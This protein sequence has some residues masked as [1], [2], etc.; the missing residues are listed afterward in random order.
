M[1][2]RA[3]DRQADNL[4]LDSSEQ[5]KKR[6]VLPTRGALR[7]GPLA[8]THGRG[9]LVPGRGA[10]NRPGA[11]KNAWEGDNPSPPP[12]LRGSPG[13]AHTV[14]AWRGDAVVPAWV[15]VARAAPGAGGSRP[16]V[17]SAG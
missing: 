15:A 3:G 4:R 17:P 16:P 14:L 2:A 7:T 1:G 10:G 8:I 12:E 9:L 11:K 5:N 13:G 6:L